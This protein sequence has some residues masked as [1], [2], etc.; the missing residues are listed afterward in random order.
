MSGF[1]K[2]GSVAK[3]REENKSE[4]TVERFAD[5]LPSCATLSLVLTCTNV[6]FIIEYS[7]TQRAIEQQH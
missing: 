3:N 5:L 1:D 2:N 7:Y 4:V 6:V